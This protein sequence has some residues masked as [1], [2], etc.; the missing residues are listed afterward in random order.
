MAGV[1][2]GNGKPGGDEARAS[3]YLLLEPLGLGLPVESDRGLVDS[4]FFISILV[5]VS[6]MSDTNWVDTAGPLV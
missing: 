6:V 5:C 3:G 1:M 2:D 4:F